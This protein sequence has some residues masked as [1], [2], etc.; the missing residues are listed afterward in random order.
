MLLK[1]LE[2]AQQ[3]FDAENRKRGQKVY[4]RFDKEL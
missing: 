3:T 2:K 1:R 4:G